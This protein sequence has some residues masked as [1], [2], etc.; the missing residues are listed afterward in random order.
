M[1]ADILRLALTDLDK[2][3]IQVFRHGELEIFRY[4]VDCGVLMDREHMNYASFF[5]QTEIVEVYLDYFPNTT[6]RTEFVFIVA[7]NNQV[8]LM[9]KLLE[10]TPVDLYLLLRNVCRLGHLETVKYLFPL[11]R[12]HFQ[13]AEALVEAVKEDQYQV[14]RYILDNITLDPTSSGV[15]L[16][17]YVTHRYYHKDIDERI[18]DICKILLD[19]VTFHPD[20]LERI[21]QVATDHGREGIATF[22]QSR[23]SAKVPE[24][25]LIRNLFRRIAA[26]FE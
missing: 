22:I 9:R 16:E 10:T 25:N 15:V 3:S 11:V 23:I 7:Q 19:R 12:S 5:D 4:F 21:V 24:T 2:A 20:F 26:I 18:L 6:F 14:V 13:R 17:V 8:R 1:Y